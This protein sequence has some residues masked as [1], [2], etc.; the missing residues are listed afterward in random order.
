MT[1]ATP[2]STLALSAAPASEA[3][4][5]EEVWQWLLAHDPALGH[6]A[7]DRAPAGFVPMQS[8]GP[9]FTQLGPMYMRRAPGFAVVMGLRLGARHTNILGIA[10]GGMLATFADGAL[11]SGLAFAHDPARPRVAMVTVSLSTDF[12]GAA[13]PGAWLEASVR[14]RKQGS[15]IAFAECDLHADGRPVLR[16]SGVFAVSHLPLPGATS[17]DG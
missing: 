2:A 17:N 10:H 11:G 12:L 8:G 4:T 7:A 16:C 1:D 6:S 9:Y 5:N 14:V 3:A 13:H 15:R